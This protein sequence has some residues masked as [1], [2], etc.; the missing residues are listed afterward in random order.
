MTTELAIHQEHTRTVKTRERLLLLL[1]GM[2]LL[3]NF[4]GLRLAQP[5]STS[6]DWLH[7]IVWLI[8]ASIGTL[9]LERNLPARD[10]LLFP[11]AMFLSGWGLIL[12]DRLAPP[13]ADRQTVWLAVSVTAMLIVATT[14]H[15]LRWLRQYRYVLLLGGILLLLGTIFL[16]T[17]PSGSQTAP[18]LWLGFGA[19]FFQPSEALKIMLVAFLASY[20]AE[21]PSFFR[22]SLPAFSTQR[23]W[24]S[25]RIIGP[26]LLMWGICIIILVWQRDLGTAILF[27]AVFILLVYVATR[28]NFILFSGFI[29]IILA[30]FVAY[31]AFA[32]VRLRVDVWINPWPEADSRAFQIV[33]SLLAFAAGGPFGQGI[34]QGSPTYIP[35]VHSDFVFSAIA[36][37]WGLLGVITVIAAIG[38]F[39]VRGLQIALQQQQRAFLVLLATGLSLLIATQSLL[40][41]AGVLKL[42]PLTGVTLPYLSYGGS[43]L[44]ASF[45]IVGLLLRL[46]A[47]EN[48]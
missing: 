28:S 8:C 18:Q 1:V 20:L 16:G 33:Q 48:N 25:P 7:F 38:T 22:A 4:L 21:S 46:S 31:M 36:E 5:S 37:E 15:P 41:M 6:T 43:S 39:V 27:F 32:V 35:V 23:K 26:V 3:V 24:P 45:V 42:I 30:G 12:I 2:F 11:I 14:P 47:L 44:L 13:F 40:I 19:I 34:G 10:P 29:L 17:N 9:L